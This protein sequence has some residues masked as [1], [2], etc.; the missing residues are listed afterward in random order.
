MK[1]DF[2]THLLTHLPGLLS[3][4]APLEHTKNFGV[5]L[6]VVP[7]SLGE[8][9]FAFFL[10]VRGCTF[11]PLLY[12]VCFKVGL[13]ILSGSF[14][15]I[16][17]K[18]VFPCSKYRN[19]RKINFNQSLKILDNFNWLSRSFGSKEGRTKNL[20]SCTACAIFLRPVRRGNI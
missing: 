15:W 6:G 11:K 16:Q 10:E 14:I 8:G 3:F 20:E 7:A 4:Y 19:V 18:L 9:T 12:P 2:F 1:T 13:S 5:S 17:Y